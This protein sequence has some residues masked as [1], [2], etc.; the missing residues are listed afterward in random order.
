M[1][2]LEK[3]ISMYAGF[4]LQFEKGISDGAATRSMVK[5]RMVGCDVCLA[6]MIWLRV[7]QPP[8]FLHL[9]DQF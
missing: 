9:N 6:G 3:A 5:S 2:E 7:A 8:A 1:Y 4:K